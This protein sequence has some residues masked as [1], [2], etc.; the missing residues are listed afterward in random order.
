MFEV[1]FSPLEACSFIPADKLVALKHPLAQNLEL[2]IPSYKEAN[3]AEIQAIQRR[4]RIPGVVKRIIPFDHLV[5]W[6]YW[7]CVPGRFLLPEDVDLLNRDRLRVESIL[8]K[9]VWLFGACCFHNGSSC[10]GDQELIFDWEKVLEFAA[11]QG[12]DSYLLDIDFFPTASKLIQ[13]EKKVS[14]N[15]IAVEPAH[16]HIEFFHLEP[17]QGGFEIVDP[18]PR[19][20]CQ[21]WTAKPF[22]KNLE[23]GTS[24]TRYDL[25][26]SSPLDI[27]HAFWLT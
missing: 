2:S 25:W 10:D 21:V 23:T 1:D 27:T 9:L 20:S 6:E 7:W 15:H 14:P 26:I 11:K 19:C 17:V 16:W 13:D 22:I 4:E 12:F 5:C 18:K 3:S 24:Q 8:E